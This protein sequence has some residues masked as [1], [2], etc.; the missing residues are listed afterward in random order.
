[1]LRT[2][3]WGTNWNSERREIVMLWVWIHPVLQREERLVVTH[4]GDHTAYKCTEKDRE[5]AFTGTSTKTSLA[6]ETW[7]VQK[8][9]KKL[10]TTCIENPCRVLVAVFICVCDHVHWLLSD[11][12][13]TESFAWDLLRGSSAEC[14]AFFAILRARTCTLYQSKG[15]P[16]LIQ[17]SW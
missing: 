17:T 16:I 9:P 15:N 4:G 3:R 1:M 13:Q 10:E 7:S 14:N 12:H 8:K 2:A 5:M 11:A 6:K